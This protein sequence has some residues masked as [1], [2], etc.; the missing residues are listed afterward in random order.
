MSKIEE[1]K[2]VI[3]QFVELAE[4]SGAVGAVIV[5]GDDAT[6]SGDLRVDAVAYDA[7]ETG[8]AYTR[9]NYILS[10]ELDITDAKPISRD[11]NSVVK[12]YALE[13]GV[14][15]T[16]RVAP[17]EAV[18]N[19]GG[20]YRIVFDDMN[21]AGVLGES[22][23]EDILC[24]LAPAPAPAEEAQPE[25]ESTFA[26]VPVVV[27]V[28]EAPVQAAPEEP[29]QEMDDETKEYIDFVARNMKNAQRSIASGQMIRAGEIIGM[30]RKMAIEL[31]C[32]RQGI[33]ENFD[34]AID[35]I[36]C[37]EKHM[38][39]KTYPRSMDQSGYAIALATLSELFDRLI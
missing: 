16:V 37:E 30:L 11:E 25:P 36:E 9:I 17:L 31:I 4:E 18:Q 6:E 21:A 3:S 15:L 35:F 39:A 10:S 13:N 14:Q 1:R 20:W 32:V 2:S 8:S 24:D 19:D 5:R 34:Q 28:E 27:P 12:M 38:L 22:V 26:P 7:S 29:K 23:S 33:E